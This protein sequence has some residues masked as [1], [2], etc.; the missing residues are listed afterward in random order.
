MEEETL[1]LLGTLKGTRVN[2]APF[3]M[4]AQCNRVA[5][6]DGHTES[7]A[8]RLKKKA[9]P[10][11]IIAAW[12]DFR[13]EPQRLRLP[14]APDQ[15]IVYM[16]AADRPQPRFDCDLG[17]GMTTAVRP[18]AQVQRPR[19]E[20]HRPLAQHNSWRRRGCP[21]QRRTSQGEGVSRVKTES[22]TKGQ[23]P[24]SVPS[25]QHPDKP[26]SGRILLATGYW[27]LGTSSKRFPA[28]DCDED[29]AGLPYRDAKAIER[30]AHIVQGRLADRPVVVVSAMAKV[31]DS[32]LTMGRAAGGG[33]RKTALKMA[34]ALRER[35]YDTAGE[36]LGTALFTEFHGTW[37]PTFEDLDGLL[38]GIGAVGEITPRTYDYVASFGEVLS[39]KIVAAAFVARGMP[40]AHVDSRQCC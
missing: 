22:I 16:T 33:D 7:V 18:L 26:L 11:E 34:R 13:A 23:L 9:A 35:H 32:L 21:A 10:E 39:S 24:Y 40:G 37:A 15:P 3:T 20:V 38:R 2:P 36:L 8:V 31:T 5:V 25:T 14:S 19:L 12:N 29:L 17:A 1:K 6:E 28:H 4:S 30:V 27:V